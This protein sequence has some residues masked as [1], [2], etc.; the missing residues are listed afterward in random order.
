[1]TN[2]KCLVLVMS[3]AQYTGDCAILN[4]ICRIWDCAVVT[5]LIIFAFRQGVVDNSK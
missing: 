5:H 4:I 3:N 2:L 1:M